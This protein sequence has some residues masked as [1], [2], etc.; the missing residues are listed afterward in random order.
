METQS[1]RKESATAQ[2][3]RALLDFQL[4]DSQ[5]EGKM[6]FQQLKGNLWK[7]T[8]GFPGRMEFKAHTH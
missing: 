7:G 5:L 6:G 2:I 1:L 4:Q 3:S 8:K